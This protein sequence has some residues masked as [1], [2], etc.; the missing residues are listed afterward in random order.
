V[1]RFQ[2]VVFDM[3]G[4]LLDSERL[5]LVSFEAACTHFQLPDSPDVFQK[6]IGANA[7]LAKVVLREGFAGQIEPEV[8]DEVWQKRYL[9]LVTERPIP[10]MPGVENLL[11]TLKQMNMPMAVATSSKTA[12]AIYKLTA[13]GIYDYFQILVG[14]DQVENSKPKPDIF[15]RAAHKLNFESKHCLAFEDSE[16]G[17]KAAHAAGMTVVQI[18]D[19]IQPS[20]D[21]LALGHIVL[22]RIDEV[23]GYKF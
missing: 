18:P 17:V 3:D 13:A 2:A 7:Q 6:L 8:F 11:A 21:L 12:G 4:L 20:D 5:A 15:L 9:E 14:G 19:L 16:N 23:I 10:L 1:D 22:N